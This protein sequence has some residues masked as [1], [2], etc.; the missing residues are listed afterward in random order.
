LRSAI[1]P[2]LSELDELLFGRSGQL[3][4]LS[5]MIA[6]LL[7]KLDEAPTLPQAW[8]PLPDGFLN[9]KLPSDVVSAWLFALRGGGKFPRE[10]HPN[11][12]Q[13][14]LALRGRALFEVYSDGSWQQHPLDGAGRIAQE[15]AISIPPSMWHR[16]SIGFGPF[17]SLSFHTVAA[18]EL[19]EET[20][21]NDDFSQI[22]RR[23]YQG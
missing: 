4:I 18:A 9:I 21:E 23:L 1:D 13:R 6:S 14:S 2:V 3:E 5:P 7:H 19:I 12:W 10:R 20:C 11:S 22:H 16:I 15:R 8:Q 17:V